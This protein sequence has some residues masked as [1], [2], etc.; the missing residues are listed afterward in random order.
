M[1]LK[2]TLALLLLVG[3]GLALYFTSPEF[4]FLT[5]SNPPSASREDPG[6]RRQL[7]RLTPESLAEI[8]VARDEQPSTHLVRGYSGSWFTAGDWP[9]NGDEVQR[10]VERLCRLESR[11]T[12]VS[13]A[14]SHFPVTIEVLLREDL[15]LAVSTLAGTAL[16]ESPLASLVAWATTREARLMRLHFAEA[17]SDNPRF[18][19]PTLLRLAGQSEILRLAP[20]L[21]DEL[22]RPGDLYRLRRLFPTERIARLSNPQERVDQLQARELVLTQKDAPTLRLV[23]GPDGWEL[24]APTRDHVDPDTAERLLSAVAD[25]WA[26]QFVQTDP[27]AVA[28]LVQPTSLSLLSGLVGLAPSL[29]L[30]RTGLD[31]PR[32]SIQVTRLD[33]SV[34]TLLLG[35][36]SRADSPPPPMRPGEPPPPPPD[37]FRFAK[38]AASDLIF[39]VQDSRLS[40]VFVPLERLRD[41]KLARFNPEDVERVELQVGPERVAL[42]REQKETWKMLTPREAD[43]DGD[44]IQNLLR[45]LS[46]LES[47]NKDLL[48]PDQ[49]AGLLAVALGKTQPLALLASAWLARETEAVLGLRT[50]LAELT[51]Q[52]RE[53]AR[54]DDRDRSKPRTLT[55]KLGKP[56]GSTNRLFV[57]QQGWPRIDGMDDTLSALLQKPSLAYRGKQ[58]LDFTAADVARLEIRAIPT[59]ALGAL[60][61]PAISR[62]PELH[63]VLTRQGDKWELQHPV[64]VAVDA[65][66][67]LSLLD[68]L[69]RLRTTEYLDAAPLAAP[70]LEVQLTFTDPGK[71]A[72]KLLLGGQADSM[73][74][75]VA[76]LDGVTDRFVVADELNRRLRAGP[77]TYLPSTLW[78]ISPRDEIVR[79]T[80]AKAGQDTYQLVRGENGWQ[81]TG[82]FSVSA[83]REV[84]ERL[85]QAL[86]APRAEEYRA[87]PAG[88]LAAYGLSKP[89]VTLTLVT[90]QGQQYSVS[91]GARVGDGAEAGRFA[92]TGLG[93][94]VLAESLAKA[95]DQSALDFLDPQLL[96]LDAAPVTLLRRQRGTEVVE[97]SRDDDTW[98]LAKPTEQPADEPRVR[99]LV[100]LLSGL[101]AEK[102]VAFKPKTLTDYGLEPP[103]ATFTLKEGEREQV[104]LLGREPSPGKRLAMLR[105]GDVVGELSAEA[106]RQLLAP[107]LTWRS[108]ELALLRDADTLQLQIGERKITFARPEGTWKVTAPIEADA[109]HDGLEALFNAVARLRADELVADLPDDSAELERYGLAKPTRRWL[110]QLDERTELDLLIGGLEPAGKRRYARVAGNPLVALLDDKL[111]NQV[112][113]EY[114]LRNVWKEPIDPAQVE[115][116]KFGYRTQPFELRKIDGTWQVVG[117]PDLRLDQDTVSDTL[118]ALR[119]LKLERYVR[120]DGAEWKLYGL[121][122]VELTLE[123]TTPTGKQTLWIGGIEGD[124]QRRYARLPTSKFKDVFVLDEQTSR[125]LT[126]DAA[127][128]TKPL[129]KSKSSDF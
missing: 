120:D 46:N 114:R 17:D 98:K 26:E 77:L 82:P 105:G 18:V 40:E 72:R 85:T 24:H 41:S 65:D 97:L 118:A 33:G 62:L 34:V 6:S 42:Q 3:S 68:S 59:A 122:P 55:L 89:E 53:K 27:S 80:I 14:P 39:E 10:L 48:S 30:E 96:K 12:L 16:T 73:A 100:E 117:Q 90:Q 79:F 70:N 13:H 127:A 99:K 86:T 125:R 8:T 121:D 87:Y 124:S 109:D 110:I 9:A 108:H 7:R 91:L 103:E 43:A 60:V 57:Q 19:R 123:V 94:V 129:P 83:P 35:N 45:S 95:I 78:Q 128:L 115:A 11:H 25:L 75:V 67:V 126:R 37:T 101:R 32:E 64:Q 31:R 58:V 4:P 104:L 36:R 69:G 88:E 81:V 84:V 51:L 21:I 29:A 93:V 47:P 15:A 38:L 63:V 2:T 71:P 66:K 49:R 28:T 50:P 61:G 92:T 1:K 76:Q 23:H 107:A 56:T 119:E 102:L 116:V 74:G 52:L 111:S 106:T 5:G 20:G 113:T 54:P 22:T 112:T 44:K